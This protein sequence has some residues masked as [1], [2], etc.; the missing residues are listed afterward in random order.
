MIRSFVAIDLPDTVKDALLE[1]GQQ[2]RQQAP[3]RSVRWSRVSGIHLTLKFLGDVSEDDLPGIKAV[4]GQV[5]QRHTPFT[6]TVEGVGCFPNAKSPRVVWVGVREDAGR[7]VALQRDVEK[8]LVPLGFKAEKRAYHP[9]LTLGRTG[10]HVRSA[11]QRRLGEV[12]AASDVGELAQVG[13][14][15]FRLMRS[16]LHPDGAVYTAL[17]TFSLSAAQGQ[18]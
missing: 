9:H 6:C 7:L 13:V 8:N 15:S 11:D 17:E 16:D 2:L 5:A 14:E 12:I 3:D 18:D 1:L 4:L 10:R